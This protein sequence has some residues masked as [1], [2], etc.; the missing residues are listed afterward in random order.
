MKTRF[1]TFQPVLLASLLALAVIP[2]ASGQILY[3]NTTGNTEETNAW[4][5]NNGFS[6]TD[7]FT[8]TNDS[9]ISGITFVS[10]TPA[11]ETVSSVDWSIGSSAFG[12]NEASGSAN[13][14]PNSSP[15]PES[16]GN[17]DYVALQQSFIIPNEELAAGTYWLTFSNATASTEGDL[18]FWDE[19]D[20]SS[21]AQ[22]F[23]G[24]IT[25]GRPSESFQILSPTDVPEG[26]SYSYLL[27]SG[28]A[29]VGCGFF[30]IRKTGK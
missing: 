20:G 19:S 23:N 11:G 5:I 26:G 24:S 17:I 8:L 28:L 10:W 12:K 9:T 16:L 18:V 15:K 14:L 21:S 13:S 6:V 25:F 1:G 22:Q 2:A 7:S 4:S 3:D 30:R 29:L 27:L